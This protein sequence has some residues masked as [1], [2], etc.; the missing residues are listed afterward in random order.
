MEFWQDRP[1]LVTGG[2]GFLGSY[3]VEELVDAGARVTVVDNLQSGTEDNIKSVR[4]RINFVRAD[5]R[6]RQVCEGVSAGLEVVFNLAGTAYGLEYSMRHH[7]E[8]LYSN[9]AVQAHMLEAARVNGVRRL[10][11]VSTS[12]VYPDDA[13]IPTPELDVL[14]GLPEQVNE[15]YGWAKRMGELQAKYYHAEYGMEIAI[16]RPFNPY[17]D[18]YRWTDDRSHVLPS[19]VKKILDGD[20][21]I[22][23]WG[24]GRQRRNFLH[25]RDTARL[26]M[27]ICERYPCARPVNIGY[28][29]DT[30]IVDLALLIC[31]I[32]G[33]HPEIV[34]DTSKPEGRFRKCADAAL[35]RK[36]TG[37]YQP[38]IGLRQGIEEMVKWYYRTFPREQPCNRT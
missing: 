13:P 14:T 22:V 18:H 27:M 30:S 1:V 8:M 5:L 20:D 4:D 25:A 21:P 6:D 36:I 15:G 9:L 16:C 26:M 31:E 7:G 10:L 17:G 3:L 11:V 38:R 28:D 34:F 12:C 19:L 35:L 23:V 29:D 33:R 24:T 32:S 2:C 37:N